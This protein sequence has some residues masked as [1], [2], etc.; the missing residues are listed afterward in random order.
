[1]LY[2][3]ERNILVIKVSDQGKAQVVIQETLQSL[4]NIFSPKSLKHY[5]KMAND[6]KQKFSIKHAND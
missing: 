1:M 3:S 6:I 5:Q 2:L 4:Q